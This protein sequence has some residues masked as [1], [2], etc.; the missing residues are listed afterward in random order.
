MKKLFAAS[1]LF[2]ATLTLLFVSCSKENL[3]PIKSQKAFVENSTEL[4]VITNTT[5][6]NDTPYGNKSNIRTKQF[7]PVKQMQKTNPD[8]PY[9]RSSI[10]IK[11]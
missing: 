4:S 1:S 8:T 10:I 11:Y 6:K 5:A 3:S 2:A 7:T 9:G